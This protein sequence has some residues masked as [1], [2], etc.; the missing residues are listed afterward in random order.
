MMRL[1]TS[2]NF[3]WR[4]LSLLE[5]FP[6]AAAAG[7]AGVELQ[8]LEGEDPRALASAAVDNGLVVALM[9]IS[10]GDLL[11]GGYGLSGVPGREAEFM[12]AAEAGLQAAQILGCQ[13]VHLGPSRVPD[14]VSREACLEVLQANLEKVLPA[15]RAA[16]VLALLEPVNPVDMPGALVDDLSLGIEIVERFVDQG[17]FLQF[18]IYHASM[19]GMAPAELGV[20]TRL[21]RHVQFSDMPGRHEPGNGRIDF[22]EWLQALRAKGYGGWLGAEYIP[23]AETDRCLGWLPAFRQLIA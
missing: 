7:F 15:F 8:V 13:H 9:N 12:A 19:M 5:R 23:S 2:V 20:W 22:G 18:D 16:G 17:L 3:M 10:M 11:S 14:G 4:E 6:R 1:S 21:I